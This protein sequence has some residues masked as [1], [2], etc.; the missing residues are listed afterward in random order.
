[1]LMMTARKK[2]TASIC[3][4]SMT[5]TFM[6]LMTE[7]LQTEFKM[8]PRSPL[9]CWHSLPMRKLM[10]TAGRVMMRQLQ[11]SSR[12]ICLRKTK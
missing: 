8:L 1:M 3:M 9:R 4:A 11:A 10:R 12:M 7:L 6:M 2:T 5:W